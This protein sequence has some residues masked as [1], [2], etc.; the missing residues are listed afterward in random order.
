MGTNTVIQKRSLADEVVARLRQE[1]STGQFKIGE[2]LPTEPELMKVYGVGRSTIREAIRILSNLGLLN[3]QQ[4]VGTFVEKQI[5][6]SE[7]IGQRFKRADVQ[8][9]DEIR[10]LFEIK[11]A[12]KA[13]LNRTKKDIENIKKHL[14]DRDIAAKE[15]KLEEC[16]KADLSF[17]IAIAE[18]S[19]N[20]IL[21]DLYKSVAI[22]MEKL[23]LRVHSD[24]HTFIKTQ[25]LHERL[26]DTIIAREPNEALN[27]ATQIIDYI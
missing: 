24:T 10:K 1:I 11:I 18:A 4:G 26:L 19:K 22:H 27:T 15:G 7:P 25:H 2:R 12:E 8:D 9:L 13:A 5:S 16:I 21:A 6:M 17:H 20:D 3:V 14:I 23:F